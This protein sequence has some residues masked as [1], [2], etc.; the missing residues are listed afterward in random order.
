MED[1]PQALLDFW[2]EYDAI[3][4]HGKLS[5][6]GFLGE[7][8]RFLDS[9]G[10]RPKPKESEPIKPKRVDSMVITP[11]SPLLRTKDGRPFKVQ[12]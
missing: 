2:R 10:W 7:L 9:D 6:K 12:E 3:A 4:A 8:G 5:L 1:I 11:D